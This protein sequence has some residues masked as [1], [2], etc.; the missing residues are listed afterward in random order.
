MHAAFQ[1]LGVY[2]STM[3]LKASYKL[4]SSVSYTFFK[5]LSD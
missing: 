3:D 4:I 2:L 1:F 5:Y